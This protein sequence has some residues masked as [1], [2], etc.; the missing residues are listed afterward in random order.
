MD[1]NR[2]QNLPINSNILIFNLIPQFVVIELFNLN[3]IRWDN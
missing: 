2:K 1:Y 3:E